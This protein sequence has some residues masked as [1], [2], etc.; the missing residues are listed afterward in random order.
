M[1]EV[2]TILSNIVTF[3]DDVWSRNLKQINI[4]DFLS[5]IRKEKYY[6]NITR[7]RKYLGSD[8]LVRYD[9]EKIRLPSV[10]FSGLFSKTRKIESLSKYNDICVIDI[11][12]ILIKDIQQYLSLLQLD[13][14]IFSFWLSP[15]GKGIKGLMKFKYENVNSIPSEIHKFAFSIFSNYLKEKYNI[16]IDKSGSDITR[17]CFISSDCNLVL[18]EKIDEFLVDCQNTLVTSIV[19]K[20][21]N[22]PKNEVFNKKN[23]LCPVGRNKQLKRL[24]IQKIIKFLSKRKLSITS[25]YENWYRVAYAISDT[26]TYD[27]GEKYYLQLCRL[28][29]AKHNEDESIAMLQYCYENS[30]K[31]ITFGTIKHYFNELKEVRGSCTEEASIKF[32]P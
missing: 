29:G 8:D 24:E 25:T 28:D 3:Q 6:N 1:I 10:T 9:Q 23:H 27:L 17:L 18:K 21:K 2:D 19:G 31:S 20:R 7:L 14:Y 13:P 12:D 15:S 32:D 4:R 22:N 26:F 11:D 5:Q 16:I 30:K